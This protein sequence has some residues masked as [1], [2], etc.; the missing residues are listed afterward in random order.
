[1]TQQGVT[2][3]HTRVCNS[4]MGIIPLRGG[5]T[6]CAFVWRVTA[7]LIGAISTGSAFARPNPGEIG[8]IVVVMM[9]NRSFDHFLGW[10][11]NSDGIQAGL[12]YSDTGGGTADT[13]TLAPDYQGCSNANPNH[14]YCGGRYEWNDGASDGWLFDCESLC[15]GSCVSGCP[16]PTD[17][18]C[19][20][21]GEEQ[22]NDTY[23]I[24][25]YSRQDLPFYSGVADNWTVCD[26]YFAPIM[27]STWPNKIYQYAADTDRVINQLDKGTDCIPDF[28]T[29]PTIFDRLS[30]AGLTARYYFGDVPFVALWGTRYLPI[31]R[32][33][34]E[35]YEAC[36]AG[37]LPNVAYVD[38]RFL[39]EGNGT[40]C[41][42]HPKADV[43]CGQAFLNRIYNAITSSPNWSNTVLVIHYDE[44][45]GFFDHVDPDDPDGDGQSD[46]PAINGTMAQSLVDTN[47]PGL[48]G[49]RVPC[50]V[51]SP[52]AARGVVADGIYDHASVLRMIEWNWALTPLTIRDANANNL[53]D[54]LTLTNPNVSAPAFT[55]G[56]GPFS[57]ACQTSEP[58]SDKWW[59]LYALARSLGFPVV[60]VP[61]ASDWGL[62][63][64]VL[65]VLTFGTILLRVRRVSGPLL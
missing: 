35:F 32:P 2:V 46:T 53:A 51:V 24:G 18:I 50:I 58:I 37:N 12:T 55:V 26:H 8:H 36:A 44:W 22:A 40:S 1:M 43:R 25:Y 49:F 42:D 54:V 56:Q 11:P 21:P 33:I 34:S 59:Q 4:E 48:R 17:P 27:A 65:T 57:G 10:V 61:A 62:L 28:V 19:W 15:G 16:C 38:P 9:E 47:H 29:L 52:W 60:D 7:L 3:E 39:S 63:V 64:L 20:I 23:A 41:D 6:R 31:A 14:S 30:D 5:A 13:H 45:G